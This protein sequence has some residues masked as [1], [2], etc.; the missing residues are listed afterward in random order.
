V[1]AGVPTGGDLWQGETGQP[2]VRWRYEKRA[3]RL[4]SICVIRSWFSTVLLVCLT[5]SVVF[6]QTARKQSGKV[7]GSDHK[8][9]SIRVT[10]SLRYKPEEIIAATGLKVGDVVT[11]DDL[12]KVTKELGETG[13]FR[14]VS[15]SYSY[16]GEGTK[17]D[18]QVADSDKLIPTHFENFVWFPA[19]E[20]M[21]KIRQHVPLFQGQV[22]L[23]GTLSD[24]VSDALQALL[25]QHSLGA[26]ADYIR[27]GKGEDGPI[28]AVNFRANDISILIDQVSFPGSRP[29]EQA[30]LAA[31]ARKMHGMDYMRSSVIAYA[32]SALLPVYLDRGFLKASFAEPEPKVSREEKNETQVDVALPVTPGAQYKIAGFS[33]VGQKTFPVEKL[34][35]M[36][37]QQP[38]EAA[39]SAKLN[40]DLE[41]IRKL[42]GTVG[43]MTAS[44]KP[45]PDF[46]DAAG[47]V[48]Y[49]L[50]VEEG[51][52]FHLGDLEIQG[53]DNKI[54]DRLREIWTLS[55]TDPYDSSYPKKFVA[56]SW[57][58][59]PTG[60]KWTANIHEAVN[61]K[62]QT[63]DV[64]V[65]YGVTE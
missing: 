9:I 13:L 23:G 34:Q 20:L 21:A 29:E 24:Q 49:V 7:G 28:E 37:H 46:D 63:V 4:K 59:L 1:V 2:A 52:V 43:R 8:L 56:Q 16:S 26:R 31:A 30:A 3:H 19:D 62:D 14:N 50:H 42:Y 44:V 27:E 39:N 6:P 5:G 22:P 38:G 57:K 32:K 53:V 58:L 51:Q 40:A 41:E 36:V 15:Y 11:D 65:R 18:L 54:A 48:S 47:T 60:L 35:N 64:S 17:L 12:K 45:E 10:G 61:E 33:W 25:L 55:E